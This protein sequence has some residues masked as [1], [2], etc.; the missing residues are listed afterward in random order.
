MN[1]NLT[2]VQLIAADPLSCFL[3]VD[4]VLCHGVADIEGSTTGEDAL[5]QK[6]IHHDVGQR[7]VHIVDAVDAQQAA[8][9]TL[10]SDGGMVVDEALH[11]VSDLGSAGPGTGHQL[12]IQ[13]QFGFHSL[14]LA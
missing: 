2:Q 5:L 6:M 13:I 8:H 4:A 12:H 3:G 1:G 11:I 14:P 10:N 9:R 7:C